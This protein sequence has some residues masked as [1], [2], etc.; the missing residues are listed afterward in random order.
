MHT[1]LLHTGRRRRAHALLLPTWLLHAERRHARLLRLLHTGRWPRR[2]APSLRL[3]RRLHLPARRLLLLHL[4]RKLLL[5]IAQLVG[6]D[7]PQLRHI[8]VLLRTILP[9]LKLCHL[10]L[11][12]LL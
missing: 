10:L 2:R 12:M 9:N 5:E 7:L 4:K 11:V 6:V 8:C 1:I 3:S